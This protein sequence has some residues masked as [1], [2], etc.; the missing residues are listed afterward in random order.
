MKLILEQLNSGV[1]I[2]VDWFLK[3]QQDDESDEEGSQAP[4]S[5]RSGN[6]SNY[7]RSI[8]AAMDAEMLRNKL[9]KKK[10]VQLNKE[11]ILLAND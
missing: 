3:E 1:A 7:S 2:S 5:A 11:E 4:N 9:K 10:N 6:V 8:Y